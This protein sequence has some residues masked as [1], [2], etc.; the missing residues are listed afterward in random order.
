MRP[1]LHAK[2]ED[3]ACS[4]EIQRVKSRA[5]AC[6]SSRMSRMSRTPFSRALQQRRKKS[7]VKPR[8]IEAPEAQIKKAFASFEAHHRKMQQQCAKEL[9]NRA[10]TATMLYSPL[11]A[12]GSSSDSEPTTILARELHNCV[13]R[14][15]GCARPQPQPQPEHTDARRV[16]DDIMKNAVLIQDALV[17]D[18][19]VMSASLGTYKVLDNG[20]QSEAR[21][22]LHPLKWAPREGVSSKGAEGGSKSL[23]SLAD[24]AFDEQVGTNEMREAREKM[25]SLVM[26]VTRV[27]KPKEDTPATD[28]EVAAEVVQTVKAA[29]LGIAMPVVSATVFRLSGKELGGVS[30]AWGAPAPC[31]GTGAERGQAILSM[32]TPRGKSLHAALRRTSGIDREVFDALQLCLQRVS[33]AKMLLC[34]SKPANFLVVTKPTCVFAIDF[35]RLHIFDPLPLPD[36]ALLLLHNLLIA[37]HVVAEKQS[38]ARE[39]HSYVEWELYLADRIRSLHE[40]VRAQTVSDSGLR[41]LMMQRFVRAGVLRPRSQP[42]VMGRVADKLQGM[43]SSY[44]FDF[45][46]YSKTPLCSTLSEYVACGAPIVLSLVSALAGAR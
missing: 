36:C 34:D 8:V 17:R 23:L 1:A 39:V 15:P 7:I 26:L 2:Q 35:D 21:Q 22:R 14:L 19:V 29:A 40:E 16:G 20:Q 31:T 28:Y 6:R 18:G 11:S 46:R 45:A 4:D 13:Q 12:A 30:S 44:I 38:T 27:R 10:Q 24:G 5:S 42:P 41:D 32:V 9:Q 43:I 33:S 3:T 37:M 25:G